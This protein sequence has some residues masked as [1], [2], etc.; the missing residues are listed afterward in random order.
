MFQKIWATSKVVSGIGNRSSTETQSILIH[1]KL[2]GRHF[3]RVLLRIKGHGRKRRRGSGLYFQ[4]CSGQGK[5]RALLEVAVALG[6]APPF[7]SKG[8]GQPLY[9]T[10]VLVTL[11]EPPCSP[12]ASLN[13]SHHG[14]G[15][16]L[17]EAEA[18]PLH[19]GQCRAC[20]PHRTPT[21]SRD[22][23]EF[24]GGGG[25]RVRL[26]E[27][28]SRASLLCHGQVCSVSFPCPGR[29]KELTGGGN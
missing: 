26:H 2:E 22:H 12:E 29:V 23:W 27:A 9:H 8:T 4:L 28:G 3:P 24:S 11:G 16:C 10:A 14:V 15:V 17:E 13:T 25:E 20:L 19:T 1:Y 18:M 21:D 5:F 7:S 6:P